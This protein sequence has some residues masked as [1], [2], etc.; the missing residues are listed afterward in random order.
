[1]SRSIQKDLLKNR[2]ARVSIT[3]DV[4]TNG[5][6]EKKELPMVM[7]V[8]SD[9]SGDPTAP[10]K[11]YR[12]RKFVEIDRDN[13]NQ[14]MKSMNAGLNLRVDNTLSDNEDEQMAVN[15]KFES[16]DDFEP[17]NIVKQVPALKRLMDTRNKLRDLLT[18][19]DRSEELT[20][21]LE[22]ALQDKDAMKK[23]AEEL[24]INEDK[25]E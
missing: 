13:F 10:L 4:E 3:Y 1:M 2:P 25:G 16:M 12:D 20:E 11:S 15:L 9:L 18:K 6:I 14:V 5:A 23:L 24:G 21:I 19:S 22:K 8:L 7:G 17:V